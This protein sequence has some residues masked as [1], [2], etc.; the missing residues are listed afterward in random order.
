M[1]TIFGANGFLG[2]E[3]KNHFKKKKI[4]FFT[5][6]KKQTNFKRNLGHIIYCVGS[7]D[8]KTNIHKGFHSNLGHL[9][10]ILFK[11]KFKTFIFL[12]STRIY[13]N[14]AKG[15][16]ENVAIKLNSL[17]KNDY[18][19]LLKIT[20][21]C[22][23]LSLNNKNIKIVRLSNVLGKNFYSPLVLPTFIKNAVLKSKIKLF[24]NKM[25]TKDYIPIND[26]IELVLKINK[27]GKEQVYN[28]ASGN[29]IK[30]IDLADIIKKETNCSIL[31]KNQK[32]I[33]REPKI[34]ISKIKKEFNY[35]PKFNFKTELV[36][37]I[38]L[39]KYIKKINND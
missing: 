19:N 38:K 5:P 7:D 22:L 31:L 39:F 2:N 27:S 35:R 29:N 9:Q 18:Y 20:S 8:W 13:L 34:N 10:K 25:S 3:F 23:C 30:L 4:K 12:S 24:V 14:S 6:T 37:L 1:Y 26:V 36:K 16:K 33:V 17:D 21:E 28:V 15:T 32:K 11:N